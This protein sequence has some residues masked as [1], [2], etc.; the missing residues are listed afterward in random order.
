MVSS[1]RRF[2][3]P[4]QLAARRL[5]SG[6][7]GASSVLALQLA[8]AVVEGWH[9]EG[10]LLDRSPVL[11]RPYAAVMQSRIH[12]ERAELPGRLG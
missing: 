7:R 6:S 8:S 3:P 2:A 9:L 1:H 10:G 11:R 4:L 12:A 5:C